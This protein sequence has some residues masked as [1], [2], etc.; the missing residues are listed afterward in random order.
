MTGLPAPQG[1][2]NSFDYVPFRAVDGFV[3]DP[4]RCTAR[5]LG[6]AR[7]GDGRPATGSA[8][9]GPRSRI[10]GRGVSADGGQ[11]PASPGIGAGDRA[12]DPASRLHRPAHLTRI[13]PPAAP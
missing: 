11:G 1:R 13:N 7:A 6:L 4:V 5:E 12:V 2:S 9:K 3:L 8:G 10:R